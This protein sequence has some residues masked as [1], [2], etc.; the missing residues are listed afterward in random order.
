MPVRML[1]REELLECAKIQ[2]IAFAFPLDTAKFEQE[3][4]EKPDP[5]DHIGFFNDDNVLTA[6]M[7]LPKYQVRYEGTW[8]DMVG[9]GGV[10]SL[11]EHRFGGAVR[12]ILTEALRKMFEGGAVFSSLYPFSHPYYRK[13]G[14]ELCQ[15]STEYE[16]P[17]EALASFR[18][19]GK[20]RMIQPGESIDAIKTVFEA[21]FLRYNMPIRREDRHFENVLGKDSYKERVYTYVLEDETGPSAY[22]VLATAE[23]AGSS[24]KVGHVREIAFVRPTG[25]SDVLGLLYRFAAQYGKVRMTLPGDIP[26]CAVVS[27]S[28][29][30]KGTYRNQHMTRVIDAKKALELKRHFDGAAYTVRVRDD[31][32]EENDGLFCVTCKDGAV[33]VQR[34]AAADMADLDVDVRTFAQLLLGFLTID[35]AMY[36]KDVTVHAN[37]ETLRQV[38]VKRQV[39]LTDHF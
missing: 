31:I 10:A 6:C 38:F 33:S 4:A 16:I 34:S 21:H 1:K 2:S 37:L 39:F 8:V 13:F 5:T 19:A 20:A 24:Q 29:E 11:P 32:I 28:Y 18:Y 26:L 23:D 3:L 9:V 14:Y 15:M 17:I 30:L 27:E 12:Q 25:L 35:E 7:E 36:K 22:V